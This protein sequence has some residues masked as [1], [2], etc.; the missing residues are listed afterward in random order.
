VTCGDATGT[1]CFQPVGGQRPG[2]AEPGDCVVREQGASL[3]GLVV[4]TISGGFASELVFLYR[5][6]GDQAAAVSF[7]ATDSVA[8]GAE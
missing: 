3:W 2:W 6:E 4:L 8:Q 1:G 7:G 5:G